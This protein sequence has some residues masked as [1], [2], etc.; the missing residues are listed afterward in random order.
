M[1]PIPLTL[2]KDGFTLTQIQRDGDIAIYRQSKAGQSDAFEVIR[3][4]F[5]EACER[6]LP[7]GTNQHDHDQQIH[8]P[9]HRGIPVRRPALCRLPA[10]A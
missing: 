8:I 6:T 2:T 4:Q 1:K 3:I 7:D 9:P 5:N 10:S